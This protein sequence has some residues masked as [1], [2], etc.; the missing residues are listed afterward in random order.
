MEYSD[1]E[2]RHGFQQ[3]GCSEMPRLVKLLLFLEVFYCGA[4][5]HSDLARSFSLVRGLSCGVG[6]FIRG[7][8]LLHE[9]FRTAAGRGSVLETVWEQ[10][11]VISPCV[12]HTSPPLPPLAAESLNSCHGQYI[13]LPFT[14]QNGSLVSFMWQFLSPPCYGAFH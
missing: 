11:A 8:Q 6:N 3:T 13:S 10:P 9:G 1:S 5:G 14:L 7:R 2:T 4:L 12:K